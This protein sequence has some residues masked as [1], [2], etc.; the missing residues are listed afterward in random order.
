MVAPCGH[1]GPPLARV[2]ATNLDDLC[3]VIGYTATRILFVWFAGRQL[4]VPHIPR[5]THPVRKLIGDS[6]F[7]ALVREFGDQ[8]IRIPGTDEENRY[9]RNRDIAVR[10][11]AGETLASVAADVGLTERQARALRAQMERDGWLGYAQGVRARRRPRGVA[12]TLEIF[13]N[14]GGFRRT[15]SPS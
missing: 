2:T 6:A 9:K 3:A 15:P 4:Y 1:S 7:V 5:D 11:A 14:E 10:L 13:G 8:H 12:S